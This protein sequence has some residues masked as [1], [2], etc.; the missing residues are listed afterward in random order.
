MPSNQSRPFYPSLCVLFGA[1]LWGV[2][3]YPMRLLE[4]GG[5]HGVWL[6][7]ILYGSVLIAGLPF[8]RR[9]TLQGL[10]RSPGLALLLLS[11]AGWTNVAFVL[12]VLDGNV[13]RV[14]LLFY[15]SPLWATLLGWL[16][17]RERISRVA[18]F[19]LVV[20]MSGA[21]LMLWD[22]Q[23]G[24]PWPQDRIDWLAL[25]AGFAFA[26]SNVATRKAQNIS[27][28]GKVFCVWSG[29]VITAL[30]MIGLF[31]VPL[32]VMSL[33]VFGG[34]VALGLCGILLMTVLV[35]Y[36]V[37]HLPVYRAAILTLVELIAGAV[38]QQL[39]TN[40]VVMPREWIG[41]ALIVVGAYLSARAAKD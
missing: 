18:V 1:M 36:G 20:A 37:T 25:T 35:Q 40:E 4:Q 11:T 14:L 41:G 2:V 29:V 28:A 24:F 31:A 26:L 9:R 15:L 8:Y 3:W 30:A 12:A 34:A 19:S 6:S 16:L 27:L 17:L 13:L 32:P 21:L 7:L 23:L 38:S 39:L 33:N 10:A 5:L 22:R